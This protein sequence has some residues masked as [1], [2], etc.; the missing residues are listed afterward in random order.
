MD[1]YLENYLM[2]TQNFQMPDYEYTNPEDQGAVIEKCSIL[3]ATNI[4]YSN[5]TK[6]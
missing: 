1:T 5:Q 2:I 3:E 6:S 4:E